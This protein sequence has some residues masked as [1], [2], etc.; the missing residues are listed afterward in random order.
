MRRRCRGV[1][2]ARA[3]RERVPGGVRRRPPEGPRA[4]RRRQGSRRDAFSDGCAP[5]SP[6][7]AVLRLARVYRACASSVFRLRRTSPRA[8]PRSP[9]SRTGQG[10]GAATGA[11][12]GSTATTGTRLLFEHGLLGPGVVAA[13]C[14]VVDDEEIGLLAATGTGVA[15]CP[16]SNAALGCGVAPLAELRTAGARVGVGTDSPASAPSF[17]F[18]E[19]LR[20]VT[21]SARA[22]SAR[23]DVLS[24]AGGTGARNPWL[25]ASPRAGWGDRVL[26]PGSG[27]I[28]YDRLP[29]RLSVSTWEDPPAQSCSR[30]APHRVIA[31]YVDGEARYEKGGLDWQELTAA[32]HSARRAMLAAPPAA[33]RWRRNTRSR[34]HHV[35]P[36]PAES[37]EVGVRVAHPRLREA[38]SSSWVSARAAST[39]GSFSAMPSAAR[40][41]LPAR[42]RRPRR[43]CAL[44]RALRPL[45]ATRGRLE[46]KGRVDEAITAWTSYTKLN[47]ADTSALR[48]L[49]DLELGQAD[50]YLRRAQLA[51]YAQQ[52]ASVGSRF[53]STPGGAP[54]RWR[55]IRS[56]ARSRPRQTPN[57]RRPPPRTRAVGSRRS[58][59]TS[60]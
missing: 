31:T 48:H 46:K 57:C 47:K 14:V 36:S 30:G 19:E 60:A 56:P 35:L 29:R 40:D 44:I 16:R 11:A 24:A 9:T 17:D 20:S 55:M 41:R 3:A 45:Q 51:S 53:G 5:G 10:P 7:M 43:T 49:G 22:R 1:R 52:E 8:A 32:A 54:S 59:P 21:L 27:P 39:W 12:R 33:G 28:M 23:P 42:S 50:L 25:R 15:H 6:R 37:G 26:G 13:H 34:E 58:A 38:G 18:F 2:G 4:V